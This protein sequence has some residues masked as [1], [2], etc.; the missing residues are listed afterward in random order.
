MLPPLTPPPGDKMQTRWGRPGHPTNALCLPPS[1]QCPDH[2]QL[3]VEA[4]W[5]HIPTDS[6]FLIF[7]PCLWCRLLMRSSSLNFVPFF[8]VV[9]L[10]RVAPFAKKNMRSTRCDSRWQPF[11]GSA[12]HLAGRLTMHVVTRSNAG[13]VTTGS[14]RGDEERYDC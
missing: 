12:R 9:V 10:I 3:F 4:F 14:Y 6:T 1:A 7:H 8:W 13:G 2:W 11:I 5:F